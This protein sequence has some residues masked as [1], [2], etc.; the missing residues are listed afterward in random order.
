MTANIF[1]Q[2]QRVKGQDHSVCKKQR[3]LTAKSVRICCLFNVDKGRGTT[4][5]AFVVASDWHQWNSGT[6]GMAHTPVYWCKLTGTGDWA[7]QTD[8]FSGTSSRRQ[9]LVS[10]AGRRMRYNKECFEKH[11]AALNFSSTLWTSTTVENGDQSISPCGPIQDWR[12]LPALLLHT[13]LLTRPKN[14]PKTETSMRLGFSIVPAVSAE[15][16]AVTCK[17]VL[18]TRSGV[19]M[20]LWSR[21]TRTVNF[22]VHL[23]AASYVIDVYIVIFAYRKATA[24]R[25]FEQLNY[26]HVVIRTPTFKTGYTG[27][28]KTTDILR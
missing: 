27:S 14:D 3:R 2:G 22:V 18:A 21:S 8:Q 17:I 15:W 28:R 13:Y 4:W 5:S 24:C 16:R 10:V 11:C 1:V 6:T 23:L 25:K 12:R 7:I 26:S 9:F 20:W 19:W